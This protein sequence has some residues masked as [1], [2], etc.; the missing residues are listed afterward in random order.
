M[1]MCSDSLSVHV[2]STSTGTQPIHEHGFSE[3]AKTSTG[4]SK[5]RTLQVTSSGPGAVLGRNLDLRLEHD[6]GLGEHKRLP[7]G[8]LRRIVP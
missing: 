3:R 2:I 1:R 8:V 6:V 7:Q 4:Q 5:Q